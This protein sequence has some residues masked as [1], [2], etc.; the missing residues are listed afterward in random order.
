VSQGLGR[1][2]DLMP[3]FLRLAPRRAAGRLRGLLRFL[4]GHQTQPQRRS[5]A[6]A[7]DRNR[8]IDQAVR[9]ALAECGDQVYWF[10]SNPTV[11]VGFRSGAGG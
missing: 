3:T 2:G 1:L 9:G 10:G 5:I 7:R 8:A 6:P 11:G 4:D